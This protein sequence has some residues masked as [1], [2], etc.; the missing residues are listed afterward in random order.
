MIDN[1]NENKVTKNIVQKHIEGNQIICSV[2]LEGI[3][4]PFKKYLIDFKDDKL[5]GAFISNVE[6]LVR[7]SKFYKQYLAYLHNDMEINRCAF[8]SNITDEDAGVEF[9]HG[10]IFNLYNYCDI[11]TRSMLED[12]DCKGITSFDVADKVME[13]HTRNLVSLVPLSTRVH[14][15]AHNN[16]RIG[17]DAFLGP[18]FID[19]RSSFG[20]FFGFIREYNESL[21]SVE[22]NMIFNYYKEFEKHI[23]KGDDNDFYFDQ[24][25]KIFKYKDFSQ[26]S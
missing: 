18:Q 22:I 17:K 21:S 5:Y 6:R 25:V 12:K 24:F 23:I 26:K 11:V 13:L 19:I 20:D 4:L 9:H 10:P 16:K 15:A 7:T 2:D 1:K 14:K 8:F 3:Y